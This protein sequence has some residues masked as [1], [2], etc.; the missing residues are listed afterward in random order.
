MKEGVASSSSSSSSSSSISPGTFDP[1]VEEF[2][3][4]LHEDFITLRV[5][6]SGF[7]PV[8]LWG[9]TISIPSSKETGILHVLVQSVVDRSIKTR[10][11]ELS[12]ATIA[13]LLQAISKEEIIHLPATNYKADMSD[14]GNLVWFLI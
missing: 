1:K 14:D 4:P 5:E 9:A 12:K 7:Q 8:V 6:N 3:G 10:I 13:A 2:L 11:C